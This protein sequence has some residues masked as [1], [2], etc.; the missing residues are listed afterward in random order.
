MDFN[1]ISFGETLKIKRTG[2]KLTLEFISEMTGVNS[3]TISRIEAGKVIP[4]IET[5]EFLSTTYKEDLLSMFLDHRLTNYSYFYEIRNRLEGKFDS[6]E[7]DTLQIELEELN[8]YINYV[9]SP[10]YKNLISQLI[11]L[12][13]AIILYS[14]EN[15]YCDS[16][17]KLTDAI[18]LTTPKFTIANYD[19][20]VYS[21]TEIRILINISFVLNKLGRKDDYQNI[22]EF[23]FNSVES[24]DKLYPRICHNLAGVYRRSQ[25]F[26]MAIEFSNMGIEACQKT[27]EFSILST[28]YYGKGIAE[29]KLNKEE[30]IRSLNMAITLCEAF[31]QINLKD[32]MIS[33]CRQVFGIDI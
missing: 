22:M 17:N 1:L 7:L 28:L 5:L 26:M 18:K 30:Y 25:Q 27:R 23:C 33:N 4:K 12:T 14:M 24:S 2:L 32:K 3:Q 9:T 16:L 6:N 10:Y 11:L 19:S 21:S 15:N 29:F 8:I 13:E 31:G 20:F